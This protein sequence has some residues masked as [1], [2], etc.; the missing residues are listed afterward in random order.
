MSETNKKVWRKLTSVHLSEGN[1]CK[2]HNCLLV[3]VPCTSYGYCLECEK[4]KQDKQDKQDLQEKNPDD[5]F[6]EV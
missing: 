3:V 5:Y 6:K 2:I 1:R 4:I